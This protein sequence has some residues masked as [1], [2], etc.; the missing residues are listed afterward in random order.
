MGEARWREIVA[1]SRASVL[2]R[3][4]NDACDAYLLSESSL[5]VFERRMLMITCGQTRLVDAVEALLD[6]L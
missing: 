2:S 6:F 1:A 4:S 3:M 5:F